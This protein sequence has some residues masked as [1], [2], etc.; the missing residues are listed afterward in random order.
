MKCPV[1]K[2][3]DLFKGVVIMLLSSNFTCFGQLLWKLSSKGNTLLFLVGGFALYGLGALLM[4]V[5][6]RFGE[7]SIL[8][9]M[10]SSGFILSLLLGALVLG[11]RIT[12]N[13]V[14]GVV[15]IIIGLIVL[16]F[17]NQRVVEK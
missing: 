15:Y 1:G 16:S 4:I 6:L 10:L 2:T 12:F 8:H 17:Q 5:A 11:E 3:S 13:K 9:P 7:L 14:L